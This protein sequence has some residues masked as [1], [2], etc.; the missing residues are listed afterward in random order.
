MKAYTLLA[1][2]ALTACANTPELPGPALVVE[3]SIDSDGYPDV[4]VTLSVQ[5]DGSNVDL[6]DAMMR[7][8]TVTISDDAGNSAVLTGAPSS[9][10][11]PPYHYFTYDIKGVPG[12]TYT[13]TARYR[14]LSVSSTAYMPY[15]TPIDSVVL[16]TIATSDTLRTATV[17]FTAPDDCP[18]Y[19]HLSTRVVGLD[20]RFLP[21]TLGITEVNEPGANVC[22]EAL[23]AKTSID[24]L[25]YVPHYPI[26][27]VALF[28]LERVEREVY[29]FWKMFSNSSLFGSSEFFDSS[30]SLPSNIEG[31][32][33]IWSPAGAST[34]IVEIVP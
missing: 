14:D 12:R 16:G 34:A 4:I 2:L 23:R 6:S 19:Y 27:S 33:G 31:G 21:A 11:F 20:G 1:L 15:P 25:D 13:L 26:G 5:A 18:A 10:H 3:G 29:D 17:H 24:T 7:M 8:A 32:Y 22:M 28:K 30:F 9:K